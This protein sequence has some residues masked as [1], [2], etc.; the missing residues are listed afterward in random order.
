MAHMDQS[1][2][3]VMRHSCEHILTH[4]MVKLYPGIKMAMGPA[5]NEGFYFDF[6][7]DGKISEG[8]FPKI[9]KEM[10]HIVKK[11]LSIT[12][13]TVTL[14]EARSLFKGNPYKQE[15]LDEIEKKGGK[16][17]VYWTGKEF[18]DLCS[19]PHITS[20][21]KVGPFK[22]LSVAGAYWRG[23]SKN[24][25]LTRIYGTCFPTKQELDKYLWQIEEAKKR[26]H[27]K[28]GE[29]LELFTI[30][31]KVGP[32]LILWLPKGNIIK[33]ELE[34]WVK[35]IEKDWGYQRVT[36]PVITKAGLYY[37]SGHLPYYKK[38][39][40]P[41]MTLDDGEQYFLRPMNCPHH[42]MI[43]V[44]KPRSYKDLP[45]RL[46][47]YGLCHRY[48]GSGEL[49]GLMRVRGFAQNDAHIY[50][51]S[52]QAVD[53]FLEVMKLHEF[54]YQKLGITEYYLELA[55]RDPK[56]K[57]KYHG[58]DKMWEEAE[59][60][61]KEAVSKTN[62]KMVE[63]KGNAAF[64][65][66]KIDFIVRSSIGREFAISTNQIDLYMGERFGLKY[67]DN[68]GL[69][70]TPV[71]IHRAPLGSHER[72]IGFLIEH[73]NGAFPL[74][75]APVQIDVLPVTDNQLEFAQK[76]KNHLLKTGFRVEV[77]TGNETL[78]KKIRHSILQKVPYMII[79]GDTELEK[80][81]GENLY[82]SVRTRM[83]KD[84]GMM[85]IK[86]F[87]KKLEEPIEKRPL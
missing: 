30:S 59:N 40:Y 24:K 21:G 68:Q 67:T 63:T 17:S 36:T 50:C 22:L 83:G 58:N 34:N 55:L 46:A 56:N 15:W 2:L 61:M 45:L 8:D 86:T 53:E 66:P 60:L 14:D 76:V 26:D 28:I 41:P 31:E 7:Y 33:E 64:Y 10:A 80:S 74:W 78:G 25:M 85:D 57:D 20:T 4:S 13:K 32:G 38:D 52:E 16:T 84:L 49:F 44:S 48:E 5:T 12:Q 29:A 37:T 82:V 77:N 23:D 73:Y 1:N 43:Y 81:K 6:E 75:L 70:K 18:V 71:I 87:I 51:T 11:N 62:I 35:K 9:E 19:G 42:H 3:E 72:F 65:G 69:L 39:M 47:E 79:I 54:F 27:R